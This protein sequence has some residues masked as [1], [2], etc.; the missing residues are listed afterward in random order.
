MS[1]ISL[2][3][4]PLM[5]GDDGLAFAEWDHFYWGF[6]PL[7]VMIIGTVLVY[8]YFWKNTVDITAE[9]G[10]EKKEESAPDAEE[11]EAV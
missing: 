8:H 1:I 5:K 11:I 3:I 6:I 9:V 7:A 4:A 10:G 2:T